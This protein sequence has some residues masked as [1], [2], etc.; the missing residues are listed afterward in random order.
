MK[1][2]SIKKIYC[3]LA[4]MC[5]AFS[6]ASCSN[7]DGDGTTE[8][9]TGITPSVSASDPY[10]LL[11]NKKNALGESFVPPDLTAIDK[12]LTMQDSSKEYKLQAKA[13][14]AVEKMLRAMHSAGYTDVFVTS[15]YRT[16]AYQKNL[17]DYYI[18]VE[19]GK[20]PN[21]SQAELEAKVL[22]YSAK[23]GTSEHQT[24]LCVDLFVS[25]CMRELENYGHEGTKNDV[26]F[27]E[28]E[29]FK[30]LKTHAHEYGF[31]LRYPE[32]KVDITGY[33]YESWHYRYVGTEAARE[34]S[35][36]SLTLEEYLSLLD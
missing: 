3:I 14:E 27:A 20:N 21:L 18:S 9:E 13:A 8:A 34:I 30:W 25:S 10:L 4:A 24:G 31:I 29:A 2:I 11:A 15:A 5:I 33:Q 7:A 6:F 35:Q 28:T 19:R 12:S 22:T 23:P 36:S 32:D 17:F 26:G 1:K 16:Y